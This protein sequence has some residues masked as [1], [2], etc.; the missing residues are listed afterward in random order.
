MSSESWLQQVISFTDSCVAFCFSLSRIIFISSLY[1][2]KIKL[3]EIR[4]ICPQAILFYYILLS[5]SCPLKR[6]LYNSCL[7]E[8]Q[9]FSLQ[10][11]HNYCLLCFLPTKENWACFC[12]EARL[13]NNFFPIFCNLFTQERSEMSCFYA[14]YMQT[15]TQYFFFSENCKHSRRFEII[16]AFCV[17]WAEPVGHGFKWKTTV[18]WN[19][20]RKG[21]QNDQHH[22]GSPAECNWIHPKNNSIEKWCWG[23]HTS[24]CACDH[25]HW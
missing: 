5:G 24:N 17:D 16:D 18:E 23:L 20:A 3:W 1:T 8:M 11:V 6:E 14:N 12:T 10:R 25:Q 13:A 19:R 22:T 2:S 9:P 15:L 7:N 4:Q 21:L